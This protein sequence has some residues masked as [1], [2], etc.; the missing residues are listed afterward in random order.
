M[1]RERGVIAALRGV[2]ARRG[3]G[4]RVI[5]A[6]ERRH[7][8]VGAASLRLES[9]VIAAWERRHCGVGAASARRGSDV[10]AA[11]EGR[12]RG[13]GA[14][15]LLCV[16]GVIVF[17]FRVTLTGWNCKRNSPTRN[18]VCVLSRMA[19]HNPQLVHFLALFILA[20]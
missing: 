14:A 2:S 18:I 4:V 11:W 10:I 6:W 7:C 8:G 1:R 19:K 12:Q 16:R 20:W 13:V 15:S 17:Y 9:G 5:A 3:S